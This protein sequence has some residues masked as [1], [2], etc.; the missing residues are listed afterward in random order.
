MFYLHQNCGR[1]IECDG[2]DDV[3][4]NLSVYFTEKDFLQAQSMMK[5]GRDHYNF[6]YGFC[7]DTVR[8]KGDKL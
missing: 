7:F 3:R 4:K 8:V 2:W 5:A 6:V 1:T